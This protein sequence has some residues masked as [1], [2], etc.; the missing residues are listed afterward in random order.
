VLLDSPVMTSVLSRIVSERA[1]DVI[2]AY[3][4]GMARFALDWPLV[5][6]PFVL[7]MVDVDSAKWSMLAETSRWPKR[8]IYRREARLLGDFEARAARA[9][10]STLVVNERER[11]ALS[12]LAPDARI[13]VIGNGI[14][15]E[16]LCPPS[17][18]SSEPTVVF[19][20]VMNYPPNEQG[21]LWLAREVW[22]YVRARYPAARLALVGSAPTPAIR[23]LASTSGIIVTGHVEDVRPH[24]WRSAVAAAPV[25][26][27]RGVQNKVLEACAAGLPVVITSAVAAG[28]PPSVLPACSVADD[29]HAFAAAICDRLAQSPAERR[30]IAHRAT[31]DELTW[32]KR[33]AQ[34]PSVLALAA[35]RKAP[36]SAA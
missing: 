32:E 36:L 3:G 18:P 33:L 4:S 34:L 24:L 9:A 21:A 29:P 31:L 26:V 19:C 5:G 15:V 7:D 14:D 20:G 2:L 11:A 16:P 28:L 17:P 27:A 12:L 10:R 23:K 30:A 22:P 13:E 8:W 35:A 1:P 6:I 25:R